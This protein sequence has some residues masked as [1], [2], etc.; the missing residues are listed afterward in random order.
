MNKRLTAIVILLL[1]AFLACKGAGSEPS[2][3]DG[4]KVF[5]NRIRVLANENGMQRAL[6][7]G[8][9]AA[10]DFK[11]VNGQMR[12]ESG[13]KKYRLDYKGTVEYLVDIPSSPFNGFHA[14]KRGEV[15]TIARS[16]E[17]EETEKGWR[18]ED[19]NLY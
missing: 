9:V 7:E 10:K 11:K 13:V 3:A 6:P 16:M 5:E 8:V 17:F 14:R 18:G 1:M 15:A 19:G 12:V 2:E 4:R